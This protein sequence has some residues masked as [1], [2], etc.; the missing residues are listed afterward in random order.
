MTDGSADEPGDL[1]DAAPARIS[2]RAPD[3]A[4]TTMRPG[5]HASLSVVAPMLFLVMW[6]SGA[7]FVKLGLMSSS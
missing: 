6:S 1:D 2:G 3:R 5:H 4:A 7:I